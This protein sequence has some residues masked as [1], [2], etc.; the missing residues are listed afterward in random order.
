MSK[1]NEFLAL[2]EKRDDLYPEKDSKYY[3]G[4]LAGLEKRL[5]SLP[6]EEREE[7]LNIMVQREKSKR[8]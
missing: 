1:A 3:K 4:I 5:S 8:S 7:L 2:T 6:S